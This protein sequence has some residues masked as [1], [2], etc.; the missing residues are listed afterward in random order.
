M[1]VGAALSELGEAAIV[2][3][4][5]LSVPLS[6]LTLQGDTRK[7]NPAYG[8]P[9]T[10]TT[11]TGTPFYET[12]P[13]DNKN[14]FNDGGPSWIKWVVWPTAGWTIGRKL[15]DNWQVPQIPPPTPTTTDKTTVVGPYRP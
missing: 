10:W 2:G 11:G 15:Y 13:M 6:F 1:A 8:H 14:Y 5:R 9:S 7:V 12:T 3:I 4:S